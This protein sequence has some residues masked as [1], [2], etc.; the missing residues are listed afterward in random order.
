[1][2]QPLVALCMM[3]GAWRVRVTV[4]ELVLTRR[5]T[6]RA[7]WSSPLPVRRWPVGDGM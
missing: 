5:E 2:P 3:E 7:A 4:V 6:D 1:M